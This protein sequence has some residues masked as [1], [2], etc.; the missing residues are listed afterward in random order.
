MERYAYFRTESIGRLVLDELNKGNA[1]LYL[2]VQD[3]GR[4]AL[5]EGADGPL[6]MWFPPHPWDPSIDAWLMMWM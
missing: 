2:M 5:M 6:T 3:D 4:P 1:E